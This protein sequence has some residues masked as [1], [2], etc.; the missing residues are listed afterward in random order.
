MEEFT[1]NNM[2]EFENMAES[3]DIRIAKAL[4]NTILKNL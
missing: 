3:G 1:V 4:V 2:E